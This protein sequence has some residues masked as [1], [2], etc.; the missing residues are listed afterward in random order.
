MLTK[1][2]VSIAVT[3][4]ISLN[5]IVVLG[6]DYK[7]VSLKSIEM[8]TA[9]ANEV[10]PTGCGATY[11]D[12]EILDVINCPDSFKQKLDCTPYDNK[13]CNSEK[14]TPC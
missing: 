1:I 13:C 8:K 3:F 14:Q 9:I 10:V 5:L 11:F 6:D 2:L 4:L 12:D 7:S